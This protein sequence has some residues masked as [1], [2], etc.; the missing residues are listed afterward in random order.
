MR[1]LL[2]KFQRK[3]IKPLGRDG[4]R[5]VLIADEIDLPGGDDF[6]KINRQDFSIAFC[7]L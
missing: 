1:L 4:E 2:I 3:I 6:F 7:F 5:D